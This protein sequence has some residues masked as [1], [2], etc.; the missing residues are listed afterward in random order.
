VTTNKGEPNSR[1]TFVDLRLYL[2]AYA[3]VAGV[4]CPALLSLSG[5]VRWIGIGIFGLLSI[6]C[7]ALVVS[8]LVRRGS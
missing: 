3:L 5:T 8:Y 7:F 1:F 6:I 2:I 4:I